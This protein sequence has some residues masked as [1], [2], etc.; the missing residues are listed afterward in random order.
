MRLAIYGGSFNP[1][2]LGHTA[3]IRAVQAAARPDAVLVIPAATPPHKALAE[4]SPSAEERFTLSRLAFG[5]LPGVTVSDLELRRAGKS[6]SADTVRAL[7]AQYPEAEL[8]CIVGTD[9][10]ET[11]EE[12]HDFAYILREAALYA[13]AREPDELER[14]QTAAARLRAEYGA[15]VTVIDTPPL[16][17]SST[18]I[19]LLAPG[20]RGVSAPGRVRAYHPRPALRR[21]AVLR[22][23]AGAGLPQAQAAA[24]GACLGL[25]ARG[26]PPRRTL[27]LRRGSCR[28]SR[29]FAR[30]HKKIRAI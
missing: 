24:R 11:F 6:Y 30:Y 13:L 10:L 29:N 8:C 3:A 4:N 21:A 15:R 9:M 7:R 27:G 25:R 5:A 20:R 28:G 16:P 23:A 22:L 17:V 14:V 19:R 1:P 18:Q 12:W 26:A 2:H